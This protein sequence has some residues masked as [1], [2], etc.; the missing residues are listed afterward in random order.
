[1]ATLYAN[2]DNPVTIT[3]QVST[4][5]SY[6]SN[7][8]QVVNSVPQVAVAGPLV[9]PQTVDQLVFPAA[10]VKGW[11]DQGLRVV[12]VRRAFQDGR[13]GPVRTADVRFALSTSGLRAT[14]E[15]SQFAIQRLRLSFDNQT[16]LAVVEPGESLGV[17]LDVNY[18]GAGVLDGVWQIAEPGSTEGLPLYRI[19]RL[20]KRNLPQTQY[21]RINGPA[22]PTAKPG[23]YLLRFCVIDPGGDQAGDILACPDPARTVEASYQ[24]LSG[25]ARAP[26]RIETS[27]PGRQ[28]TGETEFT[29]SA[30]P[31]AVVY[32]LQIY[33]R[34]T[35]QGDPVFV[36]GMLLPQQP[37]QTVLSPLV[38]GKLAPGQVYLWRINALDVHGEVVGQS[39]LVAFGIQG[40]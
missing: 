13:L 28:A 30:V 9:D 17:F 32:Q 10:Q 27:A 19:L 20:E 1:V 8:A 21:T 24:V 40:S 35:P 23:R 2:R 38:L 39:E 18:S 29:W 36:T 14:R 4:T 6:R 7:G 3:W 25:A 34:E 26:Q 5:G 15:A 12:V 37:L 33:R 11:L 22:L 31:G 16:S